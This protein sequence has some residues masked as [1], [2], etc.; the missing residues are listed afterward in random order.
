MT[1][2]LEIEADSYGELVQKVIQHLHLPIDVGTHIEVRP[3]NELSSVATVGAAT[4][5][6][7]LGDAPPISS[8]QGFDVVSGQTSF[9]PA[10]DMKVGEIVTHT[11]AIQA[12]E[13]PQKRKRRTKAEMDAER[14]AE[15]AAAPIVLP[16]PVAMTIAPLS[17]DQAAPL[18][19][20]FDDEPAPP[21]A[22][23]ITEED[24]RKKLQDFASRDN[25]TGL[26]DLIPILQE[27][28][29]S[30]VKG[31]KPEHYEPIAARLDEFL[32]G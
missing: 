27:F 31:I 7:A 13:A 5:Q 6:V 2:R 26:R 14:T 9:T 32:K 10:P 20:I 29:Y 22:T 3:K 21:T 8:A 1:F 18:T 4:A 16:I 30:K 15:A 17:P 11:Y 23:K 24:F 28:N 25:G 12:G 19:S